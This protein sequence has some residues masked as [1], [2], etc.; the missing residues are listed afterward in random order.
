MDTFQRISVSD[1][2]QKMDSQSCQLVD[3]RDEQSFHMGHIQGAQHLDNTGVQAFLESADPDAPLI[4]CCYHGN[5][6]QQAAQFFVEKDFTDVYSL[7]GGYE[8]WR[9]NFPEATSLS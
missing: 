9:L 4:I 1:A 8:A 2:K 6:S 7:D 5:S 3:I